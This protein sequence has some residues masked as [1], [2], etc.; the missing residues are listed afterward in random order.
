MHFWGIHISSNLPHA[1]AKAAEPGRWRRLLSEPTLH[2]VVLGGLL[3]LVYPWLAPVPPR[4]EVPEIVVRAGKIESLVGGWAEEW[5]RQPTEAERDELIEDEVRSEVLAHEAAARGLDR[6][7]DAIRTLLREKMELIAENSA[8]IAEPSEVELQAY[9]DSHTRDFGG[10]ATVTFSQIMLD[11][12]RRGAAVDGDAAALLAQL[13]AGGD[14]V[15][16]S[17]L[18]D[19]S[20]LAADYADL[21]QEQV[22]SMF[23]TEFAQS[24]AALEPG[25]WAGPI[26]S[27]MGVHL[28][29]LG[30]WGQV[31]PQPLDEVRDVVREE[32]HMARL[33]DARDE[34]YHALRARY[35][36][37]VEPLEPKTAA[38]TAPRATPQ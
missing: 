7:D 21:P 29:R 17:T 8:V 28:V 5:Q 19:P 33:Q 32:W 16:P 6:N 2:F 18:G 15:D 26:V 35:R 3:F 1:E 30:E 11:P 14:A 37:T 25:Q 24:L 10:G 12:G 23:G 36:I 4:P 31:A 34:A 20:E 9:Y 27:P 13:Q 38:V 22:E